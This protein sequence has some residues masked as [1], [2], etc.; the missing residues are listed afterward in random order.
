MPNNPL[1]MI[2]LSS[3][4]ILIILLALFNKQLLR[5]IKIRPPSE[6]FINPKFQRSAKITEKLGQ[7]FLAVFGLSLLVQGAGPQ[8]FSSEVTYTVSVIVSWTS[9][10]ILLTMFIVVFANW[11]AN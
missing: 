5:W 3:I 11:R 8:F 4:G 7:V 10:L 6:V 1:I 2:L 9:G